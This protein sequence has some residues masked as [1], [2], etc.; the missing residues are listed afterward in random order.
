MF[1]WCPLH[2][3]SDNA[4]KIRVAKHVSPQ[5]STKVKAFFSTLQGHTTKWLPNFFS[6]SYYHKKKKHWNGKIKLVWMA[7]SF[8]FWSAVSLHN[9]QFPQND[10]WPP[11][12]TNYPCV[13]RGGLGTQCGRGHQPMAY[14]GTARSYAPANRVTGDN[15]RPRRTV[16]DRL[17]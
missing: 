6:L 15:S 16:S 14:T 2:S 9:S 17:R 7:W 4:K 3:D 12:R 1:I 13:R 8:V 11:A 10:Y 5:N